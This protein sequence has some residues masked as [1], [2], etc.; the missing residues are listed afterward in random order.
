MTSDSVEVAAAM[1]VREDRIWVQTR[2]G[3]GHLDGFLEFPGGKL[4]ASES[5]LEALVREV[6]EETGLVLNPSQVRLL[7]THCHTYP[8][9]VVTLHFFFCRLEEE[10]PAGPGRWI[11]IRDLRAEDFPP[12]NA[13][14]LERLKR[15]ED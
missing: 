2:D 4:E 1:L 3:T 15:L 14:A 5:P 13:S 6:R 8:E 10:L 9:R 11:R 12:A 7:H